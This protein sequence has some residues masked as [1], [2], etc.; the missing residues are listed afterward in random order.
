MG[1]PSYTVLSIFG[2]V[3]SIIFNLENDQR[4]FM[5]EGPIICLGN[6][7]NF[8]SFISPDNIVMY[9]LR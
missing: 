3:I 8:I 2:H 4:H 5:S 1:V 6:Y 9:Y 7:F